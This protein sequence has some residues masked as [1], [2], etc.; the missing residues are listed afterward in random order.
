MDWDQTCNIQ[1]AV[2]YLN[3]VDRPA[4]FGD[5]QV[6]FPSGKNVRRPFVCQHVFHFSHLR[7]LPQNHCMP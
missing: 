7:L 4:I 1:K 5:A 6:N 2:Q 3:L